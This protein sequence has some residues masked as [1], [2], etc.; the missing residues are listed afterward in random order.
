[1]LVKNVQEIDGKSLVFEGTLTQ[2][3]VEI[4]TS[5]GINAL[6]SLG[7]MAMLPNMKVENAS[8]KDLH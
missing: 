6:M 8:E 7:L 3:E 2:P 4:I 1:M 5:F